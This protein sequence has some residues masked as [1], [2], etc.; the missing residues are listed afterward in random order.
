MWWSK[1]DKKTVRGELVEPWRFSL[2]F[3]KL[4]ANGK[5]IKPLK[6][7]KNGALRELQNTVFTNLENQVANVLYKE[8]ERRCTSSTSS[9]PDA[10]EALVHAGF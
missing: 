10:V 4:R 1:I 2:P 9:E 3:D 6:L 8:G 7:N 5:P